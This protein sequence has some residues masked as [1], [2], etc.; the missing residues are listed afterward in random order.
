LAAG[1]HRLRELRSQLGGVAM[2]RT[3]AGAVERYQA[4]NLAAARLILR[5][6]ARY[7]GEEAGLVVWARLVLENDARENEW[8]LT[9]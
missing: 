1:A 2:S 7:G 3:T 8:R 9:A 4:D 5:D 6:I